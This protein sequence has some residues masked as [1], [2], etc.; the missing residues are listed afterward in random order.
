MVSR[1]GTPSLPCSFGD[2]YPAAA[3]HSVSLTCKRPPALFTPQSRP[4]SYSAALSYRP[5]RS[6]PRLRPSFASACCARRPYSTPVLPP[7]TEKTAAAVDDALPVAPRTK[8][9]KVELH[10]APVRPKTAAAP[11]A[12]KASKPA[13]ATA[14]SVSAH[15]TAGSSEGIV[16]QAKADVEDAAQHGILKPPP[17]DAGRLM[18]LWHQAKE[19][20]VCGATL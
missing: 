4:L 12:P 8:K 19:L 6:E 9:Q 16:A 2:S 17:E 14:A 5:C 15:P 10:P 13:A 18:K 7:P 3:A 20:F 1:L 11:S